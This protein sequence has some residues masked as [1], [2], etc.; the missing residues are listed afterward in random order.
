MRQRKPRTTLLDIVK[1]VQDQTASDAEAVVMLT[2][3]LNSGRII[4]TRKVTEPATITA[5]AA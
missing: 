3:L 1:A 2:R 4:L 5:L